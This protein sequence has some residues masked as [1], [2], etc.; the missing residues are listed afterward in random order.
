VFV[1][2]GAD[3][4]TS[5]VALNGNRR[6][7]IVSERFGADP[8]VSVWSSACSA[9][10]S[11]SCA[12][13]AQQKPLA[14]SVGTQRA[15]HR[16]YRAVAAHVPEWRKANRIQ[17]G[18]VGGGTAGRLLERREQGSPPAGLIWAKQMESADAHNLLLQQGRSTSGRRCLLYFSEL[19]CEPL[20]RGVVY[21]RDQRGPHRYVAGWS[22]S[23]SNCLNSITEHGNLA[24][25]DSGS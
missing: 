6:L 7:M 9:R 20:R 2:L 14:S 4:K 17:R 22:G 24:A 3:A 16:P 11:S 5:L 21:L 23:P 15:T 12:G 18:G 19:H 25:M 8:T 1:V 13:V 10:S